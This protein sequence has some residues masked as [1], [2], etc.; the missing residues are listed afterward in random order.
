VTVPSSEVRE[1]HLDRSSRAVV[2]LS[3]ALLVVAV[4]V[5]VLAIVQSWSSWVLLFS[6]AWVVGGP[7]LAGWALRTGR[8][9]VV[10]DATGVRRT[11]AGGGAVTWS[12]VVDVLELPTPRRHLALVNDAGLTGLGGEGSTP[13]AFGVPEGTLVVQAGPGARRA[14]ETAWGRPARPHA[15]PGRSARR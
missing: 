2:V 4:P 15:I 14:I 7:V 5:A 10:V 6:G 1:R 3:V 11:G 9:E 12:Q 8:Y 13:G